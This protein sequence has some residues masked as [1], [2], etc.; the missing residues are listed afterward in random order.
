[1]RCDSREGEE[2]A[3]RE[4][5]RET[6]GVGRLIAVG[7]EHRMASTQNRPRLVISFPLVHV[8]AFDPF[9]FFLFSTASDV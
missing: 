6:P 9:T 7:A 2:R 5:K 3:G 4:R 8:V 1:M